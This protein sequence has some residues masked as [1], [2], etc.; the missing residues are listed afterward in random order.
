MKRPLCPGNKSKPDEIDNLI[1]KSLPL[2]VAL[3]SS[4]RSWH[5]RDIKG[6]GIR[7]KSW[8]W[9]L[10]EQKLGRNEMQGLKAASTVWLKCWLFNPDALNE[11]RQQSNLSS[12]NFLALSFWQDVSLFPVMDIEE[13]ENTLTHFLANLT[14]R[15]TTTHWMNSFVFNCAQDWCRPI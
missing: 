14:F 13:K 12:P 6:A 11:M 1:L 4:D 8:L 3:H 2:L 15:Q 10:L 7:G 5:G 9:F